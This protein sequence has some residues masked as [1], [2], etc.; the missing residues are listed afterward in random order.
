MQQKLNEMAEARKADQSDLQKRADQLRQSGQDDEA[1]K[2]EE[3]INKLLEQAPQMQQ[4]ADMA[5]KLGQCAQCLRQ[6]QGDQAAQAM[7]QVRADLERLQKQLEEMQMLDGAMEQI[8]QMRRQMNCDKCG[9]KGCKDCQ[10]DGDEPGAALAGGM[11]KGPKDGEP[12]D[13]LGE[14]RGKGARPEQKTD[15]KAYDS[16]VPQKVGQGGGSVTGMVDGPNL[17]GNARE[18]I[19]QQAESVRRGSTDPLSGQ[20]L[21]RKQSEHAREYFERF[22]EGK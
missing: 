14:G 18:E 10:G 8:S 1:R 20:R 11:G 12:G 3:Q 15:T 2:L 7:Q 4:M 16:R 9:G 19:D 5:Q 21:P 17:R 22:R 13:G 6:G